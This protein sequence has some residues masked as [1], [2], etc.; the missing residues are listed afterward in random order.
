MAANALPAA[1]CSSDPTATDARMPC[2]LSR[3][4]LSCEQL[5]EDL[6]RSMTRNISWKSKLEESLHLTSIMTTGVLLKQKAYIIS[7]H[8]GFLK[9]VIPKSMGFNIKPV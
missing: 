3:K 9:W 1:R 6:A 7:M 4:T 2:L 5:R 8:L